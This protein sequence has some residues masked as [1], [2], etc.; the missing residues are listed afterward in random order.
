MK[1]E[2]KGGGICATNSSVMIDGILHLISNEAK[3]GGRISLEGGAK[4]YGISGT[5]SGSITFIS[6]KASH[7]GGA[8]YYVDDES[9][10]TMCQTIMSTAVISETQ[11]F[12]KSVIFYSYDNAANVSSFNLFGGLLDKC[13]SLA[14]SLP[15]QLCFCH[16]MANQTVTTSQTLFKLLEGRHFRLNSLLMISLIIQ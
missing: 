16:Q 6:N 2:I 10:S 14:T 13:N 7:H 3:N 15:V 1:P 5:E 9:N 11:C 8:L 4:L 12:S